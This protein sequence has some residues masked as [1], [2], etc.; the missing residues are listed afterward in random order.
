MKKLG[1]KAR[2]A[3]AAPRVL[4]AR[5]E[6]VHAEAGGA[7]ALREQSVHAMRVAT[8]RLRAALQLFGAPRAVSRELKR[9]QDALGAVRDAQ[10]HARWLGAELPRRGARLQAELRRFR[11]RTAREV[12]QLTLSPRGRLGGHRMRRKLR[13]K[14]QAVFALV[15]VRPLDPEGAHR[16]RIAVKKL[17]YCAELLRKALRLGALLDE[18]EPLQEALG[19]LHDLDYRRTLDP[20]ISAAARARK[21]AAL[22]RTLDQFRGH[23]TQ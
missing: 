3:E 2:A 9:L 11:S 22:A 6:D 1:R 18:L 8:R 20:R 13:R 23:L 5:L 19:E 7:A 21:A 10:L 14:A 15:A 17:R 16:L 4:A 12:A